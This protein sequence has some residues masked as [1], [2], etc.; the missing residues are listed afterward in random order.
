MRRASNVYTYHEGSEA[1][2]R[3]DS[4]ITRLLRVTKEELDKREAAYQE[5]QNAKPQHRRPGK[6]RQ[7]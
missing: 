6:P 1:A 5:R 7:R 2:E 4:T 3:F